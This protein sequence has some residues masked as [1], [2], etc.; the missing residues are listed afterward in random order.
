MINES[1]G[2][3]LRA[4]DP[5]WTTGP[6]REYLGE[7]VDGSLGAI[8]LDLVDLIYIFIRVSK[9]ESVCAGEIYIVKE[10]DEISWKIHSSRCLFVVIVLSRHF[11]RDLDHISA[12]ILLKMDSINAWDVSFLQHIHCRIWSTKKLCHDGCKLLN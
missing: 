3:E 10:T 8:P 2:E 9:K 11:C 12:L 1:P 7:W 4:L 6:H 5:G